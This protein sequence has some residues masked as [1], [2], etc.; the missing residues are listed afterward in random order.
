MPSFG[1]LGAIDNLVSSTRLSNSQDDQTTKCFDQGQ[2]QDDR[3]IAELQGDFC[4]VTCS[5]DV[6]GLS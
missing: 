4:R 6:N 3:H 2:V 5:R 1:T